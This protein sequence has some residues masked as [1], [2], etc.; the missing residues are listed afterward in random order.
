MTPA[1]SRSKPGCLPR[2][3]LANAVTLVLLW[4]SNRLGEASWLTMAF[5]YLP[6]IL[7]I[8]PTTILALAFVVLRRW[9]AVILQLGLVAGW[10]VLACGLTCHYYPP[11]KEPWMRVTSFNIQRG[12]EGMD[13]VIETI[14]RHK[15]HVFCLQEA[16]STPDRPIRRQ[17][18]D[19]FPDYRILY[20]DGLVIGTKLPL[21]TFNRFPLQTGK[22]LIEAEV[23]F[24]GETYTIANVHL[25]AVFLDRLLVQDPARVPAHLRAAGERRDRQL[26]AILRYVGQR[27]K[28]ILCGDFNAPANARFHGELRSVLRDSFSDA[29]VGFGYTIPAKFPLMRL[30][31]IYSSPNICAR[32]SDV[33]PTVASDHRAI[34]ANLTGSAG[35]SPAEER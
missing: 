3:A 18:I 8:I 33:D 9:R 11:P 29:G 24:E 12:H 19:A 7:F 23:Q 30:D 4:L 16:D 32:T 34:L 28:L 21:V 31:F 2:L 26:S 35:A 10:L 17:L 27:R 13:K 1:T 15:P 14:R 5:T 6:Q 22:P 25:V 20:S